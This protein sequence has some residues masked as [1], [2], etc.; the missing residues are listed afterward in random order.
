MDWCRQPY[1]GG[2]YFGVMGPGV[3]TSCGKAIRTPVG[4]IHWASTESARRWMGYMEGAM[5]AGMFCFRICFC[6]W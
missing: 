5:E 2:S 3:L 4:R 1:S 6:F